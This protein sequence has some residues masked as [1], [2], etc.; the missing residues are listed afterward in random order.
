[1]DAISGTDPFIMMADGRGWIYSPSGLL[2]GPLPTH[3]E[4]VESPVGNLLYP[5]LGA[6]PAAIR[7]QRPENPYHETGDPRYPIVATTF[8]LTE[9]HTAGGMSRPVPW[10]AELQ[11]E[12]FAEIDPV[13]AADRGIEDAGW[14]TVVTA[15][16]EIEARALVTDRLRPLRAGGRML[17]QIALPWHFG[18][19]TGGVTGDSANDLVA[20][21]A[22][23]NV[24]IHEARA[25]SCDVRAGRRAGPTSARLAGVRSGRQVAPDQDDPDAER[26]KRA[27]GR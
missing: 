12:M 18:F 2:D 24:S 6:S 5:K 27:G 26:P 8:R 19:G 20:I 23:P 13:L 16:A 1:M 14:L 3:Y 21:A 25:F 15:R 7:W 9:H 4:P 11:P 17:H 22:D 10:L